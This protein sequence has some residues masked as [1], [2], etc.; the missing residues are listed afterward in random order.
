MSKTAVGPFALNQVFT[1][2]QCT[3]IDSNA[4]GCIDKTA[5]GDTVLGPVVWNGASAGITIN[6]SA[7]NGIAIAAGSRLF[8]SGTF[9][10]G[11][12]STGTINSGCVVTFNGA[13]SLVTATA[14]AIQ[15]AGGATDWPT[16]SATR[17][18]T[19]V[20]S[21]LLGANYGGAQ[22]TQSAIVA[23][24]D[25]LQNITASATLQAAGT[26]QPF[27]IRVPQHHGATLVSV[28][29]NVVASA[30]HNVGGAQPNSL[31][32]INVL[33]VGAAASAGLRAGNAAVAF[34]G[35]VTNVA[36]YNAGASQSWTYACNQLNV[37]DY[38]QYDYV[39]VVTDEFGANA[40]TNNVF[41][42]LTF[43][44]SGIPNM[45]FP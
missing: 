2:A 37:L 30:L 19:L 44:Y 10:L 18:R 13:G 28:T 5:A 6:G 33:R 41:S 34:S 1:S 7:T 22:W 21:C 3:T 17:S 12:S 42:S 24:I 38:T 40:F 16:F 11:A 25:G 35:P 43:S 8:C 39:V 32:A 23:G 29:G 15:L 20:S 45:Q 27:Y 36:W 4:A 31:P 9:Q 14:G 26:G